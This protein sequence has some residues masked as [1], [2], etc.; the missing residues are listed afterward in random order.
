[1]QL[2]VVTTLYRSSPYINEFY[3]RITEE[4]RKI[5]PDYEIIFVNDGCPEGSID[6]AM[7]LQKQDGRV[8]VVDL[9]R[10]FGHHKAMMTGLSYASGEKIFLID[11]D[12]E[13]DPELLGEFHKKFK[14][15]DC[16]VVYGVQGRRRGGLIDRLTGEVFYRMLNF[17]SGDKIPA[18]MVT[19]RLMSNRYVQSLL[20]HREREIF[21]AGLWHITGYRQVPF[22]VIK[23][24]KG[25][26]TYSLGKKLALTVNA[27]TSFNDKPLVFIFYTGAGISLIATVFLLKV[28][29]TSFVTRIR[30]EGWTS[31]IISIWFL[32]GLTIFSIGV[33]GIYLSRIFIETKNRPYTIVRAI[34]RSSKNG[35]QI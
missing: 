13:E 10:N 7:S 14:E 21:I 23:H 12:L 2:S 19:A 24:S 25:Q 15:H 4:A 3:R 20:L 6:I 26:S 33:I 27:V 22:Q 1:M 35:G 29:L 32:G 18:N 31:L 28:L 30:V 8:T 11:C 5:T 16:D 9:S 34:H 17:M